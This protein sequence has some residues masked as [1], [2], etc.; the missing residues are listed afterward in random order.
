MIRAVMEF[1]ERIP[2][3]LWLPTRIARIRA[4]IQTKLLAA[5]L[6]IVVSSR[7]FWDSVGHSLAPTPRRRPAAATPGRRKNTA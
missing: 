7:E 6:T 1:A 4:S 3:A 2:G 5:F